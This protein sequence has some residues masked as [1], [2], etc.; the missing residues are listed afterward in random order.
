MA[1]NPDEMAPGVA[2]VRRDPYPM[3]RASTAFNST[4]GFLVRGP[5][6]TE[7]DSSPMLDGYHRPPPPYP[8]YDEE[9]EREYSQDRSSG[10]EENSCEASTPREY[11]SH[12]HD[13]TCSCPVC[14]FNNFVAFFFSRQRRSSPHVMNAV[15]SPYLHGSLPD[16]PVLRDP[17]LRG[18]CPIF[19]EYGFCPH[20]V[21]CYLAH[22]PKLERLLHPGRPEV[23]CQPRHQPQ[24]L[25]GENAEEELKRL[26]EK[27]ERHLDEEVWICGICGYDR[28]AV[29]HC[30]PVGEVYYYRYC[31]RCYIMCYQPEVTYLLEHLLRRAVDDYQLFKTEVEHYRTRVPD[32]FKV[33]LSS[34]AHSIATTVYA[35]SLVTPKDIADA[36]N[37]AFRVLPSMS[38]MVSVGSG[39]GYV[40]HLFN[41][42]MN[43]ADLPACGP[44]AA[45]IAS[46]VPGE[47]GRPIAS[48][49]SKD[50][51]LFY[52]KRTVP[53]FA[54][55]ELER[56]YEYSVKVSTGGP[57]SVLSVDCPNSVLMLCWPPFGSHVEEQSSM[58]YEALEYFRQ[59]GGRV[60]IYIGDV[61]STGDWRFHDLREK[62]YKLVREYPVRREVRRWYPQEM[63]LI[64]AGNDTIGVYERR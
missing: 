60:L 21:G 10:E 22:D 40:E 30:M 37:A 19:R 64:Y 1:A 28:I 25:R 36:V 57:L 12:A 23:G 52:G 8:A 15:P 63:G 38:S 3:T 24:V 9:E 27:A 34:V 7:V 14:R 13:Q 2:Y 39:I 44:V 4:G 46:R 48:S 32:E 56:R 51:A 45:D 58:G 5:G 47:E 53:I 33:P 6:E 49:I 42:V 50:T 54:F 18:V 61:S 17:G 31:P 35:W 20:S 55:D 62:H 26:K 59:R 11:S 41:R 16:L 43:N 29:H